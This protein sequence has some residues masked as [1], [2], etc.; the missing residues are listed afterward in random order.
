MGVTFQERQKKAPLKGELDLTK[1]KTEGLSM[2]RA[3]STNFVYSQ[4]LVKEIEEFP[5]ES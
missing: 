3:T 2:H 5:K 4:E 1:S